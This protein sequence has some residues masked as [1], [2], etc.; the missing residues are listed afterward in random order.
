MIEELNRYFVPVTSSNNDTGDGGAAPHAEKAEQQR[1]YSDFLARNLGTSTVHV[2]VLRPD[3]SSLRG[4]D[5]GAV[6]TPGKLLAFLDDVRRELNT[7]AGPPAFPPHPASIPPRVSADS[8]AFHLVARGSPQNSWD[9]G[10]PSENWVVLNR[11]ELSGLLPPEPI[12]TRGSSWTV[13]SRVADILLMWFYPQV[14][15]PSQLNRSTIVYSHLHMIV[16]IIQ[17]G[18][19]RARIEGRVKLS[20]SF[21]P[22]RLDDFVNAQLIGFMDFVPK[23]GRIQRLRLITKEATYKD[24]PFDVALRSVSHET[25]DALR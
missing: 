18:V 4:L 22:D 25:L 23:E 10:I 11:T 19:A 12:V 13:E 6:L 15:D 17:N 1:I 2:Y 20:H 16:T 5:I 24:Y 21:Y 9:Y 3:G 14:E 7:P 8:M